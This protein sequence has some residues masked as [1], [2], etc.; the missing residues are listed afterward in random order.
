[1]PF[2]CPLGVLACFSLGNK[3]MTRN[4]KPPN[5]WFPS[6]PC[7]FIPTIPEWIEARIETTRLQT[8]E[9]QMI[10]GINLGIPLK[11]TT[12]SLLRTSKLNPALAP[13]LPRGP[14]RGVG[15]QHYWL[16]KCQVLRQPSGQLPAPAGLGNIRKSLPACGGKC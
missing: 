14:A 2:Q 9:T 5:R 4:K 11:E 12:H 1:M 15:G 16:A 3:G 7:R 10:L 13:H 8:Q 6:E